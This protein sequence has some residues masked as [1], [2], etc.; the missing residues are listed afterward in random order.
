MI[1]QQEEFEKFKNEVINY[2]ENEKK[3]LCYYQI[4]WSD[5]WKYEDPKEYEDVIIKNA[6]KYNLN[7]S[8]VYLNFRDFSITIRIKKNKNLKAEV[9]VKTTKTI[10][11][12]K[13]N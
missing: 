13:G 5:E 8:S 6:E 1:S 12:F 11:K 10:I 2:F 9:I 3:K 4:R 7:V